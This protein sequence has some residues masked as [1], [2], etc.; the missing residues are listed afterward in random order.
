MNYN[1]K[2]IKYSQ[3][4]KAFFIENIMKHFMLTHQIMQSTDESKQMHKY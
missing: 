4:K 2:I 3:K 1:F